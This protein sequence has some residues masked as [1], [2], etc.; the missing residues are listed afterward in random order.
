M[1]E[2]NQNSQNSDKFNDSFSFKENKSYLKISFERITFI[3]FV[4]FILAVIFSSKVILLSIKKIPEI[5]KITKKE[6]FRSSILDKDGNILAK[7]VPI[8]NLGINPNL[9]INKEKLLISLKLIF[10]NK[11]FQKE[12]YGKKFFY[13]KKKISPKKLQQVLLLGDK[14]FIQ[15]DS[16]AR[17]YPNGDLFSHVIGQIDN[18]NNGIS[19]IEKTFDYELTTSRE[20]LKLTLDKDL[21]Y[22]IKDELSK[23]SD[24]FQNVGSAAILM[25]INNG[26]ILSMISLPDFDLN[27]REKITDIKYINR[28]T[29]GVYEF[30]SV[31][32]TFTLAAGLEYNV[33]EPDTEFKDLKKRITCAGNSISEYDDKIPP[34]LTAEE[35]LIRSGNIGSV[36]IAEKV[37]IENYNEFLKKIGIISNLEF[38]IQEVG[39]TQIGR[40]GK[41]KLATVA[42]GHGI[43][44]TLLQLSKAY[45]IISN[46][47]YD[48]TPTLI[49]K[50]SLKRQRILNDNLSETINPILRKIVSTKEGTAGFANVKG[51]EVG[52]K[53]GTADQPSEGGYSKKK[54]NTFTSVF[55]TSDPKFVLAV[56]LD[57]PKANREFVY[58]YRDDRY[59][60]KGNW[61][62]TAGWTTVWVTGQIIDKIGPILA[63]KY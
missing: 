14:S 23:S 15:E 29:K 9:V 36:R 58:H 6:N 25:D 26:N 44:T 4:F 43:A 1:S 48:I 35:I 16:I 60:Y 62:N 13:V 17:V 3:F 53:T 33:V 11:N 38:D 52:G 55:P 19:G 63:T 42:F 28:A 54:V 2:L 56:M 57:E 61:R 20:P 7:S 39:S 5:Q 31:F 8:I 21:Q 59:P 51:Y 10:P 34:D 37:G 50:D 22:L 47:G 49:K 30:G 32:K 46:G 18:D 45:S 12:M 24:I 40:W 41:C 27:K